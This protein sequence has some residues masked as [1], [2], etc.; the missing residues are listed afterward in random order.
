MTNTIPLTHPD[1]CQNQA[2]MFV[3]L[4][5]WFPPWVSDDSLS[6]PRSCTDSTVLSTA[7]RK[8]QCLNSSS[9]FRF[10]DLQNCFLCRSPIKV[11]W[12]YL[13]F[14][15]LI[16]CGPLKY[17]PFPEIHCFI[18]YKFDTVSHPQHHRLQQQVQHRFSGTMHRTLPLADR[19]KRLITLV[20]QYLGDVHCTRKLIFV[21]VFNLDW[22]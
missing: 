6:G 16:R 12:F 1:F 10:S 13:F 21:L 3:G 18:Y 9:S 15:H 5:S 22:M 4:S 20:S 11:L 7:K 14:A 2:S 19:E 8:Q 17:Y